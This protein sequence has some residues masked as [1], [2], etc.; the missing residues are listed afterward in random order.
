MRQINVVKIIAKRN[1][2]SAKNSNWNIK[3]VVNVTIGKW[4]K[5]I[6]YVPSEQNLKIE[7]KDPNLYS[8][9]P[10]NEKENNIE[11]E[12]FINI[13]GIQKTGN[14]SKSIE[15]YFSSIKVWI[16]KNNMADKK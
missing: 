3:N 10:I 14:C 7:L 11:L 16:K 15:M 13:K 2:N 9:K 6:Q 5:Y 1:L 4:I 8:D 12:I